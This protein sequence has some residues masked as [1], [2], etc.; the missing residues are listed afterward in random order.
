M[1]DI[2][3]RAEAAAKSWPTYAR[4]LWVPELVAALKNAWLIAGNLAG[5]VVELEESLKIAAAE[6]E[7]LRTALG[8][9][10]L[11]AWLESRAER[12]RGEA[13]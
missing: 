2:I 8:E 13:K 10:N 6:N 4:L 3:E 11:I 1:S 12:L 5:E 7:Q 9:E